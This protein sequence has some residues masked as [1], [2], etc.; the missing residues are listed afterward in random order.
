MKRFTII[1][2]LAL[3]LGTSWARI[4]SATYHE[5][6][7]KDEVGANV[8][9]ITSISIYAPDSVTDAVI[10]SDRGLQ[11][12]MVIPVTESSD[13]TTLVNGKLSW[14]GPDG[15]NFS[16]TD[17]TNIANN[18]NHRA[19][20]GSE[21]TLIFPSYITAISSTTYA[22]GATATWGTNPAFTQS[23]AAGVMTFTPGADNANFVIGVSG[24]S[25]N[26]DFNIYVGTL[27]G[28][29]LD[30]GDPSLTWD[31]GAVLLNDTSNF[32]VGINTGTSTGITTI[33]N[34][35]GGGVAV[36]TDA[37][38][39]VNADD[40]YALTVSAGTIGIAATGGDIT[41]DGTDSSV[42]VRGTQAIAD[43]IWID[44]DAGGVDITSAATFDIDVTATGG[45][46]LINATENA[47]GAIS[48]IVNGG[49]SETIV[50][51]N[52]Q[53]TG[54][55]AFN[56][57]A[58]AGGIDVDFA[59][60]KNMAVTG[61]QFIFTSNEDVASAFSVI[62]DTGTSETITLVNTQGTGTGALT[63]TT[64]AAGD[65]DVNSGD[66]M[67]VDVADD[68]TVTVVGDYTLAVT[69]ATVLP[70]DVLLKTTTAL[71]HDHMDNLAATP[72]ELV[73]AVAG[74]TI[75]FVSAI[76]ALDW[77]ST[78]WTEPSAPDDLVI[79]YTN[80]SGAIVSHLLDAT[81]FATATEDT[82]AF[83]GSNV[84][85]AA[86]ADVASVAVTEANSTNKG[87]FLHNTGAEWTNSGNSQ[88]VVITYYRLH[89][90]AELG[91]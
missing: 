28:L 37:G 48:A 80:G 8:T 12:V 62:T 63:L 85:D 1:L 69:G 46:V 43:A 30:A 87:L 6:Q 16:M 72:K 81:G 11:N 26:S 3:M 25:L 56:I 61:G 77:D 60:G 23:I 22:D 68:M 67:T 64:T 9:T 33:G 35:A 27:L 44:A 82:V 32:N 7:V 29:K 18:A 15:Y 38:I 57:D 58:T 75:E 76:F 79:R 84:S 20:T 71:T 91:L 42:I 17:G 34:S 45:K 54:E 51:T 47:A 66:D 49:V 19:R 90:T 65:I 41:I 14:Y 40:S 88:V 39:T 70:N 21:G 73:A 53:G 74:N 50:W 86:G 59:T 5:V 36:D 83:L 78:A 24:T 2:M 52:T 55:D 31:G 10:Y 13:N 4:G 89:T